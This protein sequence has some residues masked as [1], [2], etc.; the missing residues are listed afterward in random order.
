M[1][2]VQVS[3]SLRRGAHR[4]A[5]SVG[6]VSLLVLS[7]CSLL[8]GSDDTLL[9]VALETQEAVQESASEIP[10]DWILGRDEGSTFN[11]SD[12]SSCN[13]IIDEGPSG[14]SQWSYGFALDLVKQVSN[15][16][17]L[18]A[19]APSED[20]WALTMSRPGIAGGEA[21]VYQYETP[22]VRLVLS[23]DGENPERPRVGLIGYSR[24]V[25]NGTTGPGTFPTPVPTDIPTPAPA[26]E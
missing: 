4:A 13:D 8:G 26:G 11:D 18:E 20:A 14:Q 21:M 10:A 19:M 16:D 9:E 25:R 3:V 1:A 22:N 15:A 12:P 6:V 24:C 2:D 5:I 7:G 23:I 17:L